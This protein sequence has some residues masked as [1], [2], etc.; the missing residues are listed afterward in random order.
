MPKY[1][2]ANGTIV[3]TADYSESQLTYFKYKNPDAALVEDFQNGVAETDASVTPGINV[4][5]GNGV[6]SSGDV[7]LDLVSN[8]KGVK[9]NKETNT[10]TEGTDY[11]DLFQQEEE[12]GVKALK[13]LI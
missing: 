2:L 7:S 13:E 10:Y 4:A 1:K 8:L 9:F 5:S 3:D 6:S 12:E 11:Q